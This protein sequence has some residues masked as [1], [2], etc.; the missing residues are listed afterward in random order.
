MQLTY[1]EIY[2]SFLYITFKTAISIWYY[3]SHDEVRIVFFHFKEC[4]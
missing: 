1:N 3:A 4:F 2:F